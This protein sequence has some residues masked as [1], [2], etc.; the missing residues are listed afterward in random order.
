M[1]KILF[2]YYKWPPF[3]LQ[4]ISLSLEPQPMVQKHTYITMYNKIYHT[5]GMGEMRNTNRI[6]VRKSEGKKLLGRPRNR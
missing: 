3:L 2:T 4:D 6:L 5:A 1:K